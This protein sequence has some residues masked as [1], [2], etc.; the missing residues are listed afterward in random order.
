VTGSVRAGQVVALASDLLRQITVAQIPLTEVGVQTWAI[1]IGVTG[2]CLM[3]GLVIF[4]RTERL[5]R[6]R[7]LIGVH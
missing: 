7:G 1:L 4:H 2:M 6:E 3:A 5:A